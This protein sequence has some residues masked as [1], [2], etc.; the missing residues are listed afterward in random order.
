MQLKITTDIRKS[1]ISVELETINFC[2][3][4]KEYYRYKSNTEYF[5]FH[6]LHSLKSKI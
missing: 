4:E 2:K 3:E 1:I 6:S 5:L